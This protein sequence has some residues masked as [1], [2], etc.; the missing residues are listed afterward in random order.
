VS[1]EKEIGVASVVGAVV[2]LA[3][4]N[5]IGNEPGEEGDWGLFILFSAVAALIAVLVF[6]RVI[7][8]SRAAPPGVNRPARTGFVVSLLGFLTVAVFWTGLPYVLGAGGALLGR[9]G[10]ERSPQAGQRGLAL[11]AIVLGVLAIVLAVVVL[12]TDEAS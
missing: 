8:R 2:A 4:A 11:A 7:P 3:F 9:I 5:V 12:V 10:E 6:G 1:R